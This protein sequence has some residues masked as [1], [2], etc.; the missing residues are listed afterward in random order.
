MFSP[1]FNRSKLVELIIGQ[2]KGTSKHAAPSQR[3]KSSRTSHRSDKS[4]DYSPGSSRPSTCI[5]YII[6]A[7]MYFW[8]VPV[9]PSR[10]F[11]WPGEPSTRYKFYPCETRPDNPNNMLW[12]TRGNQTCSGLW[13]RRK[14]TQAWDTMTYHHS[15]QQ[16][17][18][19]TCSNR[20]HKSLTS[21]FYE[22]LSLLLAQCNRYL[23]TWTGAYF[24][25]VTIL[26]VAKCSLD[27]EHNHNFEDCKSRWGHP[28]PRTS[29]HNKCCM[30]SPSHP[31]LSAFPL[32]LD[33][34]LWAS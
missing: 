2:T 6:S 21:W 1:G 18:W 8:I 31:W 24:E 30:R 34:L 33:L 11:H 9:V 14:C 27:G 4:C 13:Q 7:W 16:P 32:W 26:S 22:G 29:A 15:H 23:D 25:K 19:A 20:E 17:Y 10:L 5:L 3:H 12:N 28:P